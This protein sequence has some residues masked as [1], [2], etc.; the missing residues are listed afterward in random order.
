MEDERFRALLE[1]VTN[2][3]WEEPRPSALRAE[4]EAQKA[5]LH[6]LWDASTDEAEKAKLWGMYK[7]PA[8]AEVHVEYD[9]Y[10]KR[11]MEFRRALRRD[12]PEWH[13]SGGSRVGEFVGGRGNST[14][15]EMREAWDIDNSIQFKLRKVWKLASTGEADKAKRELRK[16]SEHFVLKAERALSATASWY[17]LEKHEKEVV[18][19]EPQPK[20]AA[21]LRQMVETLE[22]LQRRLGSLKVC[23]NPKCASGRK[24]FFKVYPN[25]R[26]C[27][28]RC[29]TKAKAVRQAKRDVESSKPSKVPN[30]TE[31]HRK[32]MAIAAEKRWAKVRASKGKKKHE[33]S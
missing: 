3:N 23:K 14:P 32:N 5:E 21:T 22:W 15:S 7:T 20:E 19:R 28:T 26:Y 12:F 1:R 25:D 24:Y 9:E 4:Y 6:D 16:M 8:P 31:E 2:F 30:F 13:Y 33:T 29:T 17:S 11:I 18:P 27:C 10:R